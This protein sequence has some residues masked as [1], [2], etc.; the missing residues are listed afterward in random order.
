MTGKVNADY[1]AIVEIEV[2]SGAAGARVS[3]V[4]DTGF[5][6]F[7]MLPTE[8]LLSLGA[9]VIDEAR[10]T[11]GDGSVALLDVYVVEIRWSDEWQSIRTLASEGDA[12]LGMKLLEGCDLTVRVV[13]GGEVRVEPV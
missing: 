1:E 8:L 7:L 4:V 3:A 10:V 12:L 2:R 13:P 5:S 11:L 9:E 6:E